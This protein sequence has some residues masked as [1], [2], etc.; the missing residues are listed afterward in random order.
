LEPT[1]ENVTKMEKQK[2]DCL[3]SS[4]RWRRRWRL[5]KPHL[6]EEQV[7][8]VATRLDWFRH[9]AICNT[10]LDVSLWRFRYLRGLAAK[11][12][13][14]PKQMKELAAAYDTDRGGG[15][16]AV[17]VRQGAKISMY[18]VPLGEV[19]R[20]EPGQSAELDARDL[21]AVAAY[22]LES[23]GVNYLPQEWM[24]GAMP[25]MDVP[26]NQHLIV[27]PQGI[28]I[29]RAMGL[30]KGGFSHRMASNFPVWQR[31]YTDHRIRDAEDMETRRRYLHLNP[32]RGGLAV[33]AEMYPYSSAYRA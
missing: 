5:A 21:C 1:L 23:V 31:G 26:A 9:F 17:P 28:T 6:T 13:T 4:T 3:G 15:A 32:V 14:D 16:E 33:G 19:S 18:R 27:T 29:E 12:T 2:A 8:E 11:L 20:A 25:L 10:T 30:I 24:R 22:V 7:A